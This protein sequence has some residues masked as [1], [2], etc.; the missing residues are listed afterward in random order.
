MQ[1]MK[2]NRVPV[3][4]R[5]PACKLNRAIDC[6]PGYRYYNR[7]PCC[8]NCSNNNVF[9]TNLA[10]SFICLYFTNLITFII[11]IIIICLYFTKA[12]S[13]FL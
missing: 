4:G 9:F 10:N 8:V 2:G 13:Y 1:E 5:L 3:L 11:I 7:R 12:H 6:Q